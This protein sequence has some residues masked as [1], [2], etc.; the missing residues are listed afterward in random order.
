MT[1]VI[2][3]HLDLYNNYFGRSGVNDRNENALNSPDAHFE[4]SLSHLPVDYSL[5]TE[6]WKDVAQ[7]VALLMLKFVIV[8]WALYEGLRFVVQRL[9]FIG[10]Y[11][12]Q[13]RLSRFVA[14]H[15]KKYPFSTK[16]LDA[17]RLHAAVN[18]KKQDYVVRHVRLEKN[19][20]SYSGLLM[21]HRTTIDN[22][23][24]VL[25]AVGN[26]SFIEENAQDMARIYRDAGCNVLM[27]N[28]PAVGR[29]E[30]RAS[31]ETM[32]D[33]Q[34]VGLSFL[35]TAIGAKEITLAGHSLGGAAIAQAVLKHTFQNDIQYRIVSQ[36]TFARASHICAEFAA[37]IFPRLKAFVLKMV[38][39]AGCEMDTVAASRKLSELGIAEIVIQASSR[40]A[41]EEEAPALDQ[42]YREE[43]FTNGDGVIPGNAS[44]A[45]ALVQEGVTQHKSWVRIAGLG[46]MDWPIFT[47]TAQKIAAL[48]NPWQQ[49]VA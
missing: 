30:G 46:H 42:F 32:G 17:A 1:T 39:W 43:G 24:W 3:S 34:D 8:P 29:S 40:D 22:G 20:V 21:G 25:Q 45:Y 44:L 37:E 14:T 41:A 7:R 15:F 2:S 9:I 23:Q 33:A 48:R 11:P 27:I 47:I 5:Q 4:G 31:P 49:Q 12:A 13:S 10:L 28:G 6:S 26:F 19:G 38:R 36:A 35:E 18:L 16:Q